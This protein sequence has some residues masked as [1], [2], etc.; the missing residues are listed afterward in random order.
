[1]HLPRRAG[2]LAALLGLIV[3]AAACGED[4]GPSSPFTLVFEQPLAADIVY[5]NTDV[6]FA[7]AVEAI[8]DEDLGDATFEYDWDFGD[9]ARSTG[10]GASVVH[11]YTNGGTF[12]VTVEARRTDRDQ[13]VGATLTLQ[14]YAAADLTIDQATLTLTD[15]VVRSGDLFRLSGNLLNIASEVPEPFD[16]GYFIGPQSLAEQGDLDAV[17]LQDLITAGAVVEL[18]RTTFPDFGAQPAQ[19]VIDNAALTGPTDL[20][21][22]D[23]VA[24]IFA[25]PDGNVGEEDEFNNYAFASRILPYQNATAEGADLFAAGVTVRPARANVLS[26]ITLNAAIRNDGN[27]FAEPFEY[28]VY[29]SANNGTLQDDDR[30]LY[31]GSVDNVPANETFSIVELSIP[32]DPPVT[33]LG[34][35]F[36][37]LQAD[38]GDA[39]EEANEDNN[40]SAS[41]RITVTDEELPG[42][43]I[44]PTQFAVLPDTTFIG[45]S[46]QIDLT[47]SNL[48]TEPVE[49]QFNCGFY[50]SEDAV[51]ITTQDR[52]L[53]TVLIG[54]MLAGDEREISIDAFVPPMTPGDYF[55]IVSCDPTFLIP[56]AD[57]V[58]NVRVAAAPISVAATANVDLVASAFTV[59]PLAVENDAP[60]TVSVDVCNE[61]SNGSTPSVVRVFISDD[62]TLDVSDSVLMES[63]VPPVN[64]GECITIL[65]EVPARCDTFV[66]SYTVFAAVDATGLVAEGDEANNVATLDAPF[67]ISGLICSCEDDAFERNDTPG[68][69]AFLNPNVRRFE[70]L[71]MCSANVDYYQIALLADET[72]RVSIDF[73]HDRGDLDMELFALDRS[74]LLDQSATLGDHEEVSFLRIPQRGNYLLRVQ[75]KT[76]ADR[77][78]YDLDIE[79]TSPQ[80]GTD[81]I[82]LNVEVDQER[83]VLG[84]TIQ[85][86]F[87]IVNLG[88]TAAAATLARVYL[89]EDTT[90]DPIEDTLIG[91]LAIEAFDARIY[92][93]LDVQIP[94]A[95]GGGRRYLAVVADARDDIPGELSETNNVGLSPVVNVD[96]ACFDVLEPNNVASEPRRLELFTEPP[97]SFTE[98]LACSD[99][100]DFYELCLSDGDFL[101]VQASFDSAVGDIDMKLYSG[102]T[103]ID[104]SEGISDSELVGVDFVAGDRCYVVEVYVAGA[105]REVPYTLTV[106]TGRAPDSLACSQIEEPSEGFGS[107][108]SLRD[109]LDDCMAVCPTADED[110][111]YLQLTPGTEVSFSLEG[112]DGAPPEDELRMTLWG[113]SRNFLSNTVSALEA[114]TYDVSLSGRHYLRVRSNG[115]GPRNQ[116]YCIRVEGVSGT[117]LVPTALTLES[118]IA[119]PGDTL[120][121]QYTLANTRDAASPEAAYTMYL[122]TDPVLSPDD[123][124]LR[125]ATLPGLGGLS[126]RTEGLRFDVP[127]DLIDGGSFYVI[128][129]VDSGENVPEFNEVNN[130]I[131]TTLTVVPRCL[132]DLA[133]PNNYADDAV[134]AVLVAAETLSSCGSADA[135]W[136]VYTATAA[137]TVFSLS[138]LDADGDLNLYVYTEGV[139]G[140]EEVGFS[141]SITD[142]ERVEIAT[143]VDEVYWI[144]V[145]QHTD[146]TPSYTLTVE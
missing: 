98:L 61:G 129:W 34:D 88:D 9:G 113:P 24:F 47:V 66:S 2:L 118:A 19:A 112:L 133:E 13:S 53:Q 86:C 83:P 52:L 15:A 107:A 119:A 33:E 116:P 102:A 96:D 55:P 127:A 70:N 121:F 124:V 91:S 59:T 111:Y 131:L 117:D 73:D 126:E 132:P 141:D 5:S 11:S 89:T 18:D 122:S 69:A 7:V 140:L 130:V 74:T 25:D 17:R 58:N 40:V 41:S 63:R 46:V 14:V 48:G 27:A 23:Y 92:R 115:D 20:P 39:I 99:N 26:V 84:E 144:E 93:C 50:F 60:T 137:S 8:G 105:G 109:F 51:L 135:D 78:V 82:V 3:L 142:N 80:E 38:S 95:S 123:R 100:R 143:D 37:V 128:L 68:N 28:A 120:R 87:D 54:P 76:E 49:R 6:A 101:T 1:M 35:Y 56:E 64:A 4:T 94:E 85:V 22:G 139:S 12:T 62:P 57:D 30:L 36:I 108:V 10:L 75:G 138:F 16:V 125:T 29:L 72:I 114:L 67:V 104:R 43:D 71:A 31:T 103:E 44:V 106:D 21:S 97:V 79:V 110:Y 42:A 136:F 45:G 90:L 65:A 146:R 81:L 145:V 77:N 134:D 32:I